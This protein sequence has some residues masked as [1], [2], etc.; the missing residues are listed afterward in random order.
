[1]NVRL[2]KLFQ[3]ILFLST[4]II[5]LYL[6]YYK[7]NQAFIAECAIQGIPEADCSLVKKIYEDFLRSNFLYLFIVIIMFLLSNISRALRWNM[8][9]KTF[10]VHPKFYNS[11]FTI[12]LGY[13]ANLG[14]PRIGEVIRAATLARYENTK[15]DK[16]MGTVI[17]D[18][19]IDV[20]F[21]LGY[22]V[23]SLFVASAELIGFLKDN[24]AVADK[25]QGVLTNPF[26]IGGFVLLIIVSII[27]IRSKKL[28]DS[29][30]G[31]KLKDF[32]KGMFEGLKSIA[33]L[34]RP[35]LF[36]FHSFMIW[37][38]YFLMLYIGFSAFE[39]TAHLGLIPALMAF[40][41][42]SIGFVIPSPGGMGTYHFLITAALLMYG[43]NG[44]DG[45]SFANI[46]FFTIQIFA[47]ILFGLLALVLL[48]VLNGRTEKA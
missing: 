45:F 12:M 5:I 1:L 7:Q 39:P 35:W 2:K 22:I 21:M 14:L 9:L 3:T 19:A 20:V 40:T 8:L 37:I 26:V 13:F 28:W 11:F 43:V 27:L 16:V 6:V 4:G 18:R 30:L 47:N 33:S 29:A 31:Q 34:E 42:G 23:I 32:I 17:I 36:V 41:L 10:G 25:V 24:S 46:M 15:M 38:L 48:P 44:A